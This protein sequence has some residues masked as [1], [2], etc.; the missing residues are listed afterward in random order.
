MV[1]IPKIRILITGVESEA[2]HMY[3]KTCVGLTVLATIILTVVA[4]L[5]AGLYVRVYHKQFVTRALADHHEEE[6]AGTNI[7]TQKV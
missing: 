1:R 6:K 3:S 7:L 2:Q 4:I 5:C